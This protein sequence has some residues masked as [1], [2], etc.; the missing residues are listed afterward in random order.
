MSQPPAQVKPKIAVPTPASKNWMEQV[1]TTKKNLE[2]SAQGEK[3]DEALA[4]YDSDNELDDENSKYAP[5]KAPL[6]SFDPL[7]I[8]K[9]FYSSNICTSL[10]KFAGVPAPLSLVGTFLNYVGS[11]MLHHIHDKYQQRVFYP[12]TEVT[13]L[14]HLPSGD[15][16]VVAK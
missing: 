10:R 3:N 5:G 4:Q 11:I 15:I 7:P 16:L 14:K 2:E 8:F 13:S 6:R 1:L 12:Y 9:N